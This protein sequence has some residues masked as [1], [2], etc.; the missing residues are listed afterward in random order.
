MDKN[1]KKHFRVEC[2]EP[3]E[4]MI[5]E[6]KFGQVIAFDFKRPHRSGINRSN[7]VRLTL[8]LRA[9]SKFEV[10]QFLNH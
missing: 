4:S 5:A 1:Q 8:L 7:L 3:K 6:T 10:A 2:A 9:S